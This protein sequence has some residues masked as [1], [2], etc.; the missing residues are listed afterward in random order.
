M[1]K[2]V[3]DTENIGLV[4][5]GSYETLLGEHLSRIQDGEDRR[6]AWSEI[7][8]AAVDIVSSEFGDAMRDLDG[9]FTM[10]F[11]RIWSP[12]YY[13]FETDAAIFSVEYDEVFENAMLAFASDEG[14]GAFLKKRYSSR[15][16]FISFTPNN[17]VDWT[18]EALRGRSQAVSAWIQYILHVACG[19]NNERVWYELNE[20]AVE[21]CERRESYRWDS[22]DD[23]AFA[24]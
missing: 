19:E 8:R 14:F 6:Q 1:K 16:G 5:V 24:A 12:S 22:E 9:H 13:N 2:I 4:S 20:Q 7:G 10:T 21:I 11:E 18:D 17:L 3:T 23:E 15:D